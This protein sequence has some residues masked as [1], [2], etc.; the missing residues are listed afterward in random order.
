[1]YPS[2][3]KKINNHLVASIWNE[4]LMFISGNKLPIFRCSVLLYVTAKF[5]T[6][7]HFTRKIY[8][9]RSPKI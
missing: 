3:D 7:M 9:N 6:F 4:N 1:M 8:K 5:Q 2:N